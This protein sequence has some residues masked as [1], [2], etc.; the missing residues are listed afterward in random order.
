MR[1]DFAAEKLCRIRR[2]TL[3]YL[4]RRQSGLFHQLKFTEERRPVNGPY[5][6]RVGSRGDSHTRV[7]ELLQIRQRDIVSLLN[8]IERG[9]RITQGV[10]DSL[11][12]FVLRDLC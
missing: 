11:W 9:L 10:L 1:A 6:P 4:L 5:V 8:S 12:H 2:G 7:F 3:Q